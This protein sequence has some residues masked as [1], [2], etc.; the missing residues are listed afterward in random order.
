MV[1]VPETEAGPGYVY[2]AF[3]NNNRDTTVEHHTPTMAAPCL[4]S[5]WSN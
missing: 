4:R 5:N 2:T 3:C 1:A